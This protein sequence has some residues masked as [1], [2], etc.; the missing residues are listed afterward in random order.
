MFLTFRAIQGAPTEYLVADRVEWTKNFVSWNQWN[1]FFF[2]IFYTVL[3]IP[4]CTLHCYHLIIN[5]TTLHTQHSGANSIF[6][7][8]LIPAS[9]SFSVYSRQSIIHE[10]HIS[11]LTYG[12][13]ELMLRYNTLYTFFLSFPNQVS[14][15]RLVC[16]QLLTSKLTFEGM[17]LT[18]KIFPY[19]DFLFKGGKNMHAKTY[20][21]VGG[22]GSVVSNSVTTT[23]LYFPPF[24]GCHL[25]NSINCSLSRK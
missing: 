13:K 2:A 6:G 11:C 14:C 5:N 8:N 12:M 7:L 10:C 4:I 1:M 3:F 25:P 18:R 24:N 19:I 9:N 15:N 22:Q 20:H 23:V 21:F 17:K 16:H